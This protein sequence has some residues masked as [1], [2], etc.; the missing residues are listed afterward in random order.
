M[1]EKQ[2]PTDETA[3]DIPAQ[4]DRA[5]RD[6]V[7]RIVL[8]LLLLVLVLFLFSLFANRLAPR[9]DQARIQAYVIPVVSQVAGMVTEVLVEN[10]QE[11]KAG[12]PLF[13]IAPA[14]YEL[15]LESA[16][17]E[18]AVAGQ[19]VGANTASVA[20]AQAQLVQAQANLEYVQAQSNRVFELERKGVMSIAEGDKARTSVSNA[21]TKVKTAQ[22]EL[23]KSRQLLGEE[24]ENNPRIR[25]AIAALKQAELDLSRTTV[26]APSDGGITNLAV[27]AGNS[28]SV[29]V[30][31]MTF[32]DA[33]NVWLRAELSENSIAHIKEGDAVEIALDVAPGRIFPG[34]VQ[35]V[36]FAVDNSSMAR[37]G[38]LAK[39]SERSGWLRSAQYFPVVV[40]FSDESARG[41]RRVGGQA[42]VQ[43]YTG[44][45]PLLNAYGWLWI[46]LLSWFSYIY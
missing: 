42:D 19:G 10:D 34:V 11:V 43:F 3:A 15:A 16:R 1:T 8:V 4:A 28:A 37:A 38:E 6:P 33:E 45:Y 35:S 22:A 21:E 44:D 39:S 18:L 41:L 20:T 30:P 29:G 14:D 26:I 31:L 32:I 12:Q 46:R 24:G 7:N 5:G 9:T 23:N 36:S 2:P 17:V 13:R 40:N 27:T 25:A